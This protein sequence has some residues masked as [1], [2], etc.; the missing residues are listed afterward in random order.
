LTEPGK[1]RLGRSFYGSIVRG[2]ALNIGRGVGEKREK[3]GEREEQG[4]EGEVA[5]R[6]GEMEVG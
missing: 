1:K 3:F 2:E 6:T 4:K 5:L